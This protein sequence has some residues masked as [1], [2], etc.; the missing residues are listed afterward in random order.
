MRSLPPKTA[1]RQPRG[2]GKIELN[3]ARSGWLGLLSVSLMLWM[4]LSVGVVPVTGAQSGLPADVL[5]DQPSVDRVGSLP[6][7]DSFARSLPSGSSERVV[8]V[9]VSGKLALRVLEQPGGQPGHVTDQPNAVSHFSLAQYYGTVGLIAHN[10]LAGAEFFQ[11]KSGDRIVLLRESG[12]RQVFT[13]GA[14]RRLQALSPWSGM[15]SFRDLEQ[16]G[17]TLSAL[18]LFNQVYAGGHPLVLQTCITEDGNPSWGRLFVLAEPAPD[19]V[20]AT[21]MDRLAHLLTEAG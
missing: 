14:I 19:R 20:Q 4:A 13:V 10:T 6:S 9:F 18:A 17:L 11:L 1:G 2:I 8:G 12:S 15:S 5:P 3:A 7:L 16:P 21:R